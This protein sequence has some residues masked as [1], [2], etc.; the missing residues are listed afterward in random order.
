LRHLEER[1]EAPDGD[2]EIVDRLVVGGVH[3]ARDGL[4][5]RA[6]ELA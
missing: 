5:Q 1:A 3:D 6:I 4:D 2:A